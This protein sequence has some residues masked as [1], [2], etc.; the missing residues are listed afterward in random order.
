MKPRTVM[1]VLIA[2]AA[3]STAFAQGLP[4]N[5]GLWETTATGTDPITGQPTTET[6][7]EC[8]ESNEFDPRSLMEDIEGCEVTDQTVSGDTLTFVMTCNQEGG[9]GTIQGQFQTDGETGTGKM[10]MSFSSGGQTMNFE[11]AS[12]SK[13][14]GEC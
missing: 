4:F 10:R 7:Q 13:R 3:T 14:L 1:L 8:L 6:R 11:S 2:L 9:T 5:P 12:T